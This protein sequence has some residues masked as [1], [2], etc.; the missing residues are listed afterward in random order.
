MLTTFGYD[1]YV[2]AALDNGAV[3]HFSTWPAGM[4]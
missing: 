2:K 3:W 1:E 4:P